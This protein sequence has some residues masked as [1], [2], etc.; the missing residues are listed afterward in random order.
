MPSRSDLDDKNQSA[1]SSPGFS[2]RFNLLLDRANFKQG[3][4]RTTEVAAFFEVGRPTAHR[5]IYQD[6][7]PRK[8]VD[9]V[10]KLLK[11]KKLTGLYKQ[12]QLIVWLEKGVNDP[13]KQK[14][15]KKT[16]QEVTFESRVYL[17]IIEEARKFGVN[18]HTL[19]E[20]VQVGLFKSIF[21]ELHKRNLIKIDQEELKKV[22]AKHLAQLKLTVI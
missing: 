2:G 3:R 16:H 21:D 10:L 22:A 11:S 4:G 7:C 8:L 19:E 5:W 14:S 13:L 1:R 12:D 18:L 17:T 20:S 9:V 15:G 6:Y